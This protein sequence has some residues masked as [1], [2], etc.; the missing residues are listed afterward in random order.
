MPN[1]LT[2]AEFKERMRIETS[3]EDTFCTSLLDAAESY[4]TDLEN[5]ILGRP[6]SPTAFSE[7]FESFDAV[8]VAYPDDITAFTVT[9][10]DADN[11][12]Q[13]LADIYSVKD[14]SLC[15]DDFET[16]PYSKGRVTVNYT[17]GFATVPDQIKNA[18]YFV[19]GSFYENRQ[20]EG[21]LPEVMNKMVHFMVECFRRVNL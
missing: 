17:A 6:I 15:L 12:T 10:A 18:C 1:F 21:A 16:W 20:A 3:D 13:T 8:S 7:E 9:Y 19:A 14:G 5:G 2:L 11:A 4:V